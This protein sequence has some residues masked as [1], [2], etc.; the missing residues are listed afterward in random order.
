MKRVWFFTL[1]LTLTA[2]L[3]LAGNGENELT[4]IYRKGHAKNAPRIEID[5]H[6][7]IPWIEVSGACLRDIADGTRLWVEG[8]IKSYVQGTSNSDSVQQQPTQWVIVMEVE[9]CR[10]IEKPFEA[11]KAKESQNQQ[12]EGRRR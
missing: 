2:S 8:K 9:Q 6:G 12:Q 1:S 10:Q 4:G 3:A 7:T 11:P 5:G